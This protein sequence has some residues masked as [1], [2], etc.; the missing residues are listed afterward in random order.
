MGVSAI[1]FEILFRSC[2][3]YCEPHFSSSY[4]FGFTKEI[5]FIGNGMLGQLSTMPS[6]YS[7]SGGCFFHYKL[8]SDHPSQGF[9]IFCAYSGALF[10][11]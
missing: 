2:S 11:S 3:A 7:K 10:A 1:V 6:I 5:N 4:V 9:S 8:I